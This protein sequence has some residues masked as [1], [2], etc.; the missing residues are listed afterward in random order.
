MQN[1]I[2]C[3][4]PHACCICDYLHMQHAICARTPIYCQGSED[5]PKGGKAQYKHACCLRENLHKQHA[6]SACTPDQFTAR[7]ART[8][9]REG[10]RRS[11]WSASFNP[12][13]PTSTLRQKDCV[14]TCLQIY[15]CM[16][17]CVHACIC[18]CVSV[19][20]FVK[21]GGSKASSG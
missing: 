21:G 20:S 3:K 5:H 16:C 10:K 1:E 4:A 15:V 17:V 19:C 18:V 9:Q 8:A 14:F 6:M 13:P 7:A 11:C 2:F 12:P